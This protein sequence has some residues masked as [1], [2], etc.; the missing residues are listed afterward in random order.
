MPSPALERWRASTLP[1]GAAPRLSARAA[2]RGISCRCRARCPSSLDLAV[3]RL[4]AESRDPSLE[5]RSV[6]MSMRPQDVPSVVELHAR[7]RV[8]TPVQLRDDQ[9]FRGDDAEVM[10]FEGD[11]PASGELCAAVLSVLSYDEIDLHDQ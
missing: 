5:I 2:S 3:E 4:Q 10:S 6:E 8:P 7:A 11:P 9:I 1:S